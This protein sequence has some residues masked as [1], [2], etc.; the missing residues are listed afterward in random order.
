MGN[1]EI[2]TSEYIAYMSEVSRLERLH[3]INPSDELTK[4]L[5][6]LK[7][8]NFSV[9]ERFT[10]KY[11][12]EYNK[13]IKERELTFEEEFNWLYRSIMIDV[14]ADRG[15]IDEITR[16]EMHKENDTWKQNLKRNE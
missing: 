11:L 9:S 14:K 8:R 13:E 12:E 16:A 3:F 10:K 1:N 5:N 6:A 15:Q 7:Q 2:F 4:R